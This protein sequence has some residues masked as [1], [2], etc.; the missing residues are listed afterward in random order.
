[1][2]KFLLSVFIFFTILN[3]KA[4][5]KIDTLN[6][7][8]YQIK[9]INI[10]DKLNEIS[11]LEFYD[12]HFWGNNDSG[13][14]NE[15]YKI[16]TESGKIIQT[17]VISNAENKD[18]EE[19]SFGGGNVFIAD[20][21]NNL[22]NR[23][24]LTIYYFPISELNSKTPIIS[25]EAKKIE[26]S[27]PE[28]KNFNPGNLKTNFDCEAFIYYNGKLHLFTKEWTNLETTHYTLEIKHGKQNAKKIETFKTNYLVTGATIDDNP[29][30]NTQGFYLIG[31]TPDGVSLISGFSL[32]K[33]KDD[34]LFSSKTKF[35]LPL[36]F[37]PEIGQTE[38]I[39]IKPN[40]PNILCYSAEEFNK[41]PFYIKQSIQCIQSLAD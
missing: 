26:F 13:G 16:D 4:Q 28:Q 22:G 23:K 17:V 29:I 38:G 37:V 41:S 8:N 14:K 25:V 34:L 3:L 10:P 12:D 6:I 15:I 20:T 35:S 18:W 1:M 36:G 39:A 2:F 5:S 9:I 27:Y 11:S 7:E 33:R 21:G 30:S 32:S 31:Y 24:D 40:N 19:I